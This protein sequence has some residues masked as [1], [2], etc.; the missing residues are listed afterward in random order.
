MNKT[1]W[2]LL[3]LCLAIVVAIIGCGNKSDTSAVQDVNTAILADDWESVWRKLSASDLEKDPISRILLEQAAHATNRRYDPKIRLD[4]LEE[5]SDLNQWQHWASSFMTEHP[6]NPV[7]VF[8]AGDAAARRQSF[9]DA[10]ALF[11]KALELRPNYDM[12]LSSRGAVKQ[13]SGMPRGGL[14]DLDSAIQANPEFALAYMNRGN[15]Y[16]MVG[17]SDKAMYDYS[18][19]IQ[20]CEDNAEAFNN[21]GEVSRQNGDLEVAEADFSAAIA[22][23]PGLAISYNNR[24]L[25]RLQLDKGAEAFD[26]LNQSVELDPNNPLAYYNRAIAWF[27]AGQFEEAVADGDRAIA[28]DS[29]RGEFYFNKA[30]ACEKAGRLEEAIVAF[31]KYAD[32]VPDDDTEHAHQARLKA[33]ML[34]DKLEKQ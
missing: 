21:R 19:V 24:G 11:T 18:K 26:D 13:A 8:L 17:E 30:A 6:E 14:A 12:A 22:T 25:V 34:R 15:F 16:R 1:S 27:Q 10:L 5:N 3:G 29:T 4:T 28:L 9:E 32:L 7:A 2:T 31:E 33:N 20:L 23:D